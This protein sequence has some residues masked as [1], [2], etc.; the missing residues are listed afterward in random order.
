M[1]KGII[2]VSATAIASHGARPCGGVLSPHRFDSTVPRS[3][4]SRVARRKQLV[5]AQTTSSPA[6]SDG[7]TTSYT[8]SAGAVPPPL[9]APDG[10]PIRVVHIVAELAPFA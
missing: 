7:S 5:T 8:A 9:H 10:R 6:A 3:L 4:M 1:P 2:H